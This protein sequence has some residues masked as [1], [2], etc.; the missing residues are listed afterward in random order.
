MAD[1]RL[2]PGE[3]RAG[4]KAGDWWAALVLAGVLAWRQGAS[5]DETHGLLAR[6]KP[7]LVDVRPYFPFPGTSA[8]DIALWA[9]ANVTVSSC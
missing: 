2:G 6:L 9:P 1:G 5:L 4:R 3:R 8:A 7:G